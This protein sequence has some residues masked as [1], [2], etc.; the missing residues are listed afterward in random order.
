MNEVLTREFQAYEVKQALDQMHPLKAPGPNGM[1]PLFYQYFWPIVG[2][3]VTKT[4]L[5]FLN[6]NI[7]LPNFNN[8]HILIPKVKSPSRVTDYHPISLCNVVYKLAAKIL[9]N[10]LKA[11]LF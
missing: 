7:T 9:A 11:I 4:I 8:T 6:S 3:C 5:K 10:R 1:S 2:D